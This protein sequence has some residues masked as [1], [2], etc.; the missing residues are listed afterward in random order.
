MLA[1]KFPSG[2]TI[3]EHYSDYF[4]V[5]LDK[6]TSGEDASIGKLFGLVETCKD[7]SLISEYSV[8]LTSME[9]IFQSFASASGD[10]EER[11]IQSATMKVWMSPVTQELT[12]VEQ[13][14][15]NV[16]NV[17]VEEEIKAIEVRQIE[18]E[19]GP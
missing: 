14:Q 1:Y 10:G 12:R 3:V 15:V 16:V 18:E 2:I 17:P 5:K 8:S 6:S 13:Q 9:Q 7:T 4:K 19:V 11:Q